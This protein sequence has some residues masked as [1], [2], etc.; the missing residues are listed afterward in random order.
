MAFIAEFRVVRRAEI[1]E[2]FR[3]GA[4]GLAGRH[5]VGSTGTRPPVFCHIIIEDASSA[6]AETRTVSNGTDQGDRR[7]NS[8]LCK[9]RLP[10]FRRFGI[11]RKTVLPVACEY[12]HVELARIEPRLEKAIEYVSKLVFLPVIAQGPVAE[13]LE[14][15]RVAVITDFLDIFRAKRPL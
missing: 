10:Y 13:H 7:I 6:H 12:R 4:A 3:I 14:E 11:A 9:K 15:C 8:L 2:K 5:R 1:V